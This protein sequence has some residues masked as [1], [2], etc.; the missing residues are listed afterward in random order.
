MGFQLLT[1][2]H[3]LLIAQGL[4]SGVT[5]VA[6]QEGAAPV[7]DPAQLVQQGIAVPDQQLS[8]RQGQRFRL[9]R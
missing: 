6:F 8:R 2:L 4:A 3:Q 5:K 1:E 9:P 7:C